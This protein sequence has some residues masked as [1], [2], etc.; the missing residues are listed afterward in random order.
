MISRRKNKKTS[1]ARL[2]GIVVGFLAIVTVVSWLAPKAWPTVFHGIAV[3]VWQG[4]QY[5]TSSAS[6]AFRFLE[7]KKDL[8]AENEYL[9]QRVSQLT[10]K[11]F[12]YAQIAHENEALR[13]IKIGEKE[14]SKIARV[15]SKPPIT[16][17]D[18]LTIDIGLQDG[19]SLEGVAFTQEGYGIGK[20][21][22]ILSSSASVEMFSSPDQEIPASIDR[23]GIEVILVGEGGG[24]FSVQIS[25]DVDIRD[26]DLVVKRL[27][28]NLVPVAVIV[29]TEVTE[30]D[31]LA[32]FQAHVPVNIFELTHVV[33]ES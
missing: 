26:G 33:I 6:G 9:R 7:P 2:V 32:Y 17:F 28:N 4:G 12:A 25:K 16:P 22:N 30:G 10:K 15:L 23:N 11:E 21:K 5:L 3:P 8:L 19:I 31:P 27:G 14:D 24:N 20:I 29:S 1:Y 13:N 18:T